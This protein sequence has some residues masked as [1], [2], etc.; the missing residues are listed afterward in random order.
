MPRKE[1]EKELPLGVADILSEHRDSTT[2]ECLKFLKREK[3]DVVT[4]ITDIRSTAKKY[5]KKFKVPVKV[6]EEAFKDHPYADALHRYR[7]GKSTIYLHPILAYY[8]E[9]Y[10]EG[11]IE[12]EI[13]HMKVERK[14]EGVL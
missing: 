5:S 14:W 7:R 9:K 11:C 10:V 3:V 2:S 6:S 4:P 1:W 8:P 12:H 13:D